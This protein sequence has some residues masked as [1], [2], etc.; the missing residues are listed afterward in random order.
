MA[1]T[2]SQRELAD[3][4]SEISQFCWFAGW[5]SGTEYRLWRFMTDPSDDEAWGNYPIPP[6][7][8]EQ[9]RQLSDSV[10]GWIYWRDG[11]DVPFEEQGMTFI[12]LADWRQLYDAWSQG[13]EE[14]NVL[15]R[16]YADYYAYYLKSQ[17]DAEGDR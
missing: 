8:R 17:T 7:H 5:L 11:A 2:E 13:Q 10:G 3:V 12:G 14:G 1:L 16:R 9:L 4:M 15:P 6:D